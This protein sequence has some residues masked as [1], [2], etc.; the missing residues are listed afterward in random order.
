ML[1]ITTINRKLNN[2]SE[3]RI[4]TADDKL[5]S[6]HTISYNISIIYSSDGQL[7]THL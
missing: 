5:I 6:I 4:M 7:S 1:A 3:K 2:E